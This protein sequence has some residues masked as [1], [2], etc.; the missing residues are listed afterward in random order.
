MAAKPVRKDWGQG[1][2]VRWRKVTGEVLAEDHGGAISSFFKKDK[3]TYCSKRF[4]TIQSTDF[5]P[6]PMLMLFS[7][8][9][10]RQ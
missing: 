8:F 1:W 4:I 5:H 7:V 9:G 2:G 3:S 6:I 10:I